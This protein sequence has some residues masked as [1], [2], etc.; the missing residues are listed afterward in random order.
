M[1]RE[2][3]NG[4]EER[5]EKRWK[6]NQIWKRKN[7]SYKKEN[8]ETINLIVDF[9]RK[10]Q[11]KLPE[12]VRESQI[13]SEKSRKKEPEM[14]TKQN[15]TGV[16]KIKA[17]WNREEKQEMWW[18]GRKNMLKKFDY[19]F[20]EES[21]VQSNSYFT[22]QWLLASMSHDRDMDDISDGL[23]LFW[24]KVTQSTVQELNTL[25]QL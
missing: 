11:N 16:L 17:N 4:K 24:W 22:S 18:G 1:V 15:G 3:T 9:M 7:G 13:T 12:Y 19:G 6:W 20:Y 10:K 2:E 8:Y 14:Q 5:R 23:S 21:A 25:M